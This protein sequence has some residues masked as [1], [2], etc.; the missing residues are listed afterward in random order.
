M[1]YFTHKPFASVVGSVAW[2]ILLSTP[3]GWSTSITSACNFTCATDADVMSVSVMMVRRGARE[4]VPRPQ[5]DDEMT[6]ENCVSNPSGALSEITTQC[7]AFSQ[8]FFS[9]VTLFA[10]W[11]ARSDVLVGGGR[12]VY[13]KAPIEICNFPQIIL[14]KISLSKVHFK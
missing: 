1:R 7:W 2:V 11:P 5:P 4:G 9:V 10:L 6:T 8:N 13:A 3:S 12:P 14:T